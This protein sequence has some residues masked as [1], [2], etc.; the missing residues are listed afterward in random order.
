ME[1]GE[2]TVCCTLSVVSE[3]N[4]GAGI[5]CKYC[6]KGCSIYTTRPK[7]CKEFECAYLQGGKNI[8]LRPDRCGIMFFK[9]SNR[10]MTGIQVPNVA[11]TDMAKKQI[12]SFNTQGYSVIIRNLDEPKALISLAPGHLEK[13]IQNEYLKSLK[14][15]N[16]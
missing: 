7:V 3:L 5:T 14:H 10:L 9:K 2:C 16:I 15:G 11:I 8:E 4:K 6:D 13:D 1:C 12:A